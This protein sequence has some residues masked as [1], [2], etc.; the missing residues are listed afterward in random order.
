MVAA[1]RTLG[2]LSATKL[3]PQICYRFLNPGPV[4]N[5]EQFGDGPPVQYSARETAWSTGRLR[6][7]SKEF[8]AS[9]S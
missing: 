2:N 3:G 1:V 6:A 4:S 7:L 9:T 8:F 5:S